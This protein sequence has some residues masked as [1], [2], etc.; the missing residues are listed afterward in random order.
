[1]SSIE[2]KSDFTD[3][4]DSLNNK[5]SVLKYERFLSN[6]KQRGTALKILRN[7]GIK[8]IDIKPVNQYFRGDGLLVVYTN[9]N[10]HSS[11]GKRIMTVDDAMMSYGHCPASI[12]YSISDMWIKYL[13]VGNRRFTL[14]FKKGSEVSLEKGVLTDIR[15]T[16]SE[17]NPL[18]GIP[19]FSI[20]YITNG[21]E[22][23]ATDFNEVQNLQSIGI[24]RYMTAQEVVDQIAGALV[25]YN[26]V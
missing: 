19:I 15:E 26:K 2:I 11:T 1:M 9:P 21:V 8:T 25:A 7:M 12:Y 13:Q 16:R 10:G 22:T 4:Y 5:E 23:L 18:V 6:S 20:D 17:Y 14:Y 3:Y 24:D